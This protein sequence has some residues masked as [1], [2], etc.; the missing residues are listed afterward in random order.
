MTLQYPEITKLDYSQLKIVNIPIR[1]FLE[2][3]TAEILKELKIL[4]RKL[5]CKFYLYDK[6][7]Y[8][9]QKKN[10]TLSSIIE[11]LHL[12][13]EGDLYKFM[14]RHKEFHFKTTDIIFKIPY[15]D[16]I[17]EYSSDFRKMV[18][19]VEYKDINKILPKDPVFEILYKECLISAKNGKYTHSGKDPYNVKLLNQ[20]PERKRAVKLKNYCLNIEK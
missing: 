20:E 14:E 16:A 3:V 13:H 18:Y 12:K 19:K 8:R 7:S 5:S 17:K 9:K 6:I 4:L 15:L 10:S 2:W 11:S 1:I